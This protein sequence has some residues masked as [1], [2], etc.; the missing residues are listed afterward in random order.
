MNRI[1]AFFN[2]KFGN[3]RGVRI[4]GNPYLFGI[5]VAKA[6]GY[7]NTRDALIRHVDRDNKKIIS[8]PNRRDG[9]GAQNFTVINEFGIYELIFKSKLDSAKEFQK[10]VFSEVLPSIRKFGMYDSKVW[11][12]F[13]VVSK[14]IRRLEAR[15]LNDLCKYIAR[16]SRNSLT[17]T[18]KNEVFYCIDRNG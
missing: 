4:E 17:K 10:W 1:N 18:S 11:K 5:D 15:T 9:N 8:N 14:K 3:I 6:L 16:Q 2:E 13:R 7:S 12:S